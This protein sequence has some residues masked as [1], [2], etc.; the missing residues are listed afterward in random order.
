LFFLSPTTPE[1]KTVTGDW[2]FPSKFFYVGLA[3]F[4]SFVFIASWAK[5]TGMISYI[6]ELLQLPA[7]SRVVAASLLIKRPGVVAN[8][9]S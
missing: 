5:G 1:P 2:L 3:C 9:K 8:R 6:E 7:A 4:I